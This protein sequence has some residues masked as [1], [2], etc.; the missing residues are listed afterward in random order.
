MAVP[1]AVVNRVPTFKD[2]DGVAADLL[3]KGDAVGGRLPS[4]HL[5]VEQG[6]AFP[7]ALLELLAGLHFGRGQGLVVVVPYDFHIDNYLFW[8][9]VSLIALVP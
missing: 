4:G 6:L 2:G 8:D 3:E 1:L 5:G 9:V 7:C